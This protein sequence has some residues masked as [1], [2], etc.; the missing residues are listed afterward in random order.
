VRFDAVDIEAEPAARA[1]LRE[2]GVP[3]VPAVVTA[4]GVVHGWNPKAVAELVGVQY[5]GGERLSPAALGERLDRVLDAAGRLIQTVGPEHL[6]LQ[7]PG[8]DRSL[9]QLAY[10]VFRLS[11]A[12]RDAMVERRLLRAWNNEMAP[13]GLPDGPAL[14]GY[15]AAV[16]GA[17]SAWFETEGAVQGTVETYDGPQNAHEVLE[18]TVWHALQHLRQIHALLEDAGVPAPEPLDRSLL[19]GLPLPEAVW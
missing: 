17:L 1:R 14:A 3:G 12:F 2:L 10:H 4:Q 9:H 11:L 19:A 8:R 6:G 16:R 7:H 15:G 5:D 13:A 18:R